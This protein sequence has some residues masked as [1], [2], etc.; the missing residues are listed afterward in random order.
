MHQPTPTFTRHDAIDRSVAESDDGRVLV[1]LFLRGGADTL[2][3]VPPVG[4]DRYHAARPVLRV[5]AREA[6]DLDGYFALHP[7]LAPLMPFWEQ[8][9]LSITHGTGTEDDSRSHFQAQ[10]VMEHGGE[11]HGS[12]WL[13]RYLRAGSAADA[14]L[15]A[16]AIGSTRPESLRGA[17]GGTVLQ[18]IADFDLEAS[19][20]QLDRLEAL[21]ANA[22]AAAAPL[23]HPRP[24]A[25]GAAAGSAALAGAARSTV[26]AVRTLRELRAAPP[27]QRAP[28]APA[29]PD[30]TFGR[31]LSELARLIR[32]RVGLRVSTIDL[33]GWDTHFVQANFIGGLMSQLAQGVRAFMH[34][35]GEDAQRTSVVVMTE[36]GRRLPENTSFGT[37]HGA[38]SAMFTL[39]PAVAAAKTAGVRSAWPDLAPANLDPIGDAPATRHFSEELA[40]TLRWAS[41]GVDLSAVFK[42]R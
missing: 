13:A 8:G 22:G 34:D 11:G 17:P 16:V 20:A 19:P 37:D 32:A 10:D 4:D 21:Y 15:A 29:Y 5:N 30:S 14:A 38:G 39:G 3:L 24:D 35:L 26:R 7:A 1:V 40:P 36:F 23:N 25:A 33:D 28:G 18:H 42:P 31:G 6:I 27:P 2:T 12:G 9:E 41:P